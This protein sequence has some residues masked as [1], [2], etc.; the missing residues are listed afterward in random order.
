MG[1]INIRKRGKVF[2]YSFEIAKINGKR[3]QITKSG[4]RTKGEALEEGTKAY[5]EYLNTG[6]EFKENQISYNDYLDYW[7]ENYC[8]AN[9]KYNTVRHI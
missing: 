2:Q 6:I 4:F 8:K 9:L 3:K 1:S 5:S 7:L